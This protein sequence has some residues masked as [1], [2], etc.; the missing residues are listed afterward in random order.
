M[1]AGGAARFARR[2][3]PPS[4]VNYCFVCYKKNNVYPA[5]GMLQSAPLYPFVQEQV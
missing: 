1:H 3:L 4:Y 2:R 5:G